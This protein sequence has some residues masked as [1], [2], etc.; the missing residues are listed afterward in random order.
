MDDYREASALLTASGSYERY[1]AAAHIA[2]GRLLSATGDHAGAEA[3]A[4]QA[5][6]VDHWYAPGYF[7]LGRILME[8]GK[9]AE[10]RQAL[11][12]FRK[13]RVDSHSAQGA[14]WERVFQAEL[15]RDVGDLGSALAELGKAA[16]L[17]PEH[18]NQEIEW[19]TRG[20]VKAA[21]GD[22]QGAIEA[23]RQS[24]EPRLQNVSDL[25]MATPLPFHQL[26]KLEEE[27]GQVAAAR[28]HY[29]QFLLR[30]GEADMEVPAVGEALS[31]LNAL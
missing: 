4:R 14:F 22:I 13:M 23:F 21:F 19:V 10:A 24:L 12:D 18:R 7:W 25:N 16:L 20:R 15:H 29:R 3:A 8:A 1:N 30:W 2:R 28:R 17:P 9:V 26:A 27:A 11:A 6:Q 5:L 31:R